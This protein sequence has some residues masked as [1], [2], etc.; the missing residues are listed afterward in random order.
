[1]G[2]KYSDNEYEVPARS[3]PYFKLHGS[4]NWRSAKDQ[5]LLIVGD[6]K[7]AQIAINPVLMRYARAFDEYLSR[8]NTRLMIIGYGFADVHINEI[9]ATNV[10][11][12][13]LRFFVI[14]PNGSRLAMSLNPTRAPGKIR[15]GTSLEQLFEQGL[16]G[17]SRRHLQE[18]FGT[19]M[20]EW[21]KVQRFFEPN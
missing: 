21:N 11:L 10:H 12:R 16:I 3:Q 6:Q 1:L 18:I 14:D 5:S 2:A 19:D 13:D 7:R 17:A 4:S 20:A 8:P 9:I 15:Q